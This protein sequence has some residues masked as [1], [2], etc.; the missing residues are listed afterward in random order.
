MSSG[1]TRA[2]LAA[3]CSIGYVQKIIEPLPTRRRNN[4]GRPSW[5]VS[6][7]VGA[8]GFDGQVRPRTLVSRDLKLSVS[9]D[10]EVA[11]RLQ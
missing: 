3:M 9:P 5:S 6:E 4:A 1:F 11:E 7:N 10:D 2:V 8:D